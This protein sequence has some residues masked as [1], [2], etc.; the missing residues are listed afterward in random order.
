VILSTLAK[1]FLIDL[2]SFFE[3]ILRFDRYVSMLNLLK[4]SSR[5][6]RMNVLSFI[7]SSSRSNKRLIEIVDNFYPPKVNSY[8]GILTI[9][10]ILMD[11]EFDGY[12]E[13]QPMS[14]NPG[15][16]REHTYRITP[17]GLT[18]L[19]AYSTPSSCLTHLLV[20]QPTS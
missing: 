18:V 15:K 16:L 3:A 17:C 20:A 6:E 1:S 19:V 5:P 14:S 7:A 12:V 11:L 2:I 9:N 10:C 4:T 8:A 13:L